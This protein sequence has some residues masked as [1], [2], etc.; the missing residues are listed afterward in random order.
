MTAVRTCCDGIEKDGDG[1]LEQL[2]RGEDI[3]RVAFVDIAM[4]D[5]EAIG[6]AAEELRGM[7]QW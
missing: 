6:T 4:H 2:M 5:L 1:R 3:R 7:E